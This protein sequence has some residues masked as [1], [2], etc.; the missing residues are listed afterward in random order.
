MH[1]LTVPKS[2]SIYKKFTQHQYFQKVEFRTH[3]QFATMSGWQIN[4]EIIAIG[5]VDY[6]KNQ[7][8]KIKEKKKMHCHQESL[9]QNDT[10]ATAVFTNLNSSTAILMP[11]VQLEIQTAQISWSGHKILTKVKNRQFNPTWH[12]PPRV[13]TTTSRSHSPH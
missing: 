8:S 7:F 5:L 6:L 9:H 10:K 3:P 11:R 1:K 12:N 2:C 4:K 13:R